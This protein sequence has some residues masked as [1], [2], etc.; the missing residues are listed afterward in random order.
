VIPVLVVGA[1]PAGLAT[2]FTLA[3]SGVESL[4]VER[5]PRPS[6]HPRA[7][8]ISTRSMEHL[9][10][11]GIDDEVLAGGVEVDWLMWH[12][13]TLA[14]AADGR[15]VEVGL[16]TRA[17][18]ALLSP[19][20]PACVPQDHLERVLLSRLRSL[21]P[22]TVLTSTELVDLESRP[23][24]V[25]AT[26]RDGAGRTR[27]VL[28]RY[29]VAADGARSTIRAALGIPMDGA[30]DVLGAVQAL[31]HAP[32][33]PSLGGQRYGAYWIEREGAQGLFLPA[34]A[35]A[36]LF[37]FLQDPGA[38]ASHV[39][40]PDEMTARIRLAAGM[41]ELPV[42]IES[43]A[44]FSSAAQV[45]ARFRHDDVF[46]VGDAAHRL[47][48][49][50]GTGMN[51]A[52]HDG[53]DLGWKLAWVLDG[54]ADPA[55]LDTYELERRPVAE[56]NVARSADPAGSTRSADE[57]LRADL[58]GRIG[59]HWVATPGGRV[60]TLDLV[61]P[62]LTLFTGPDGAAVAPTAPSGPPLVH[63]A[64]D[65]ITARALGIFGGGGVLVRPD[66]VPVAG[67]GAGLA[68]AA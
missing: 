46:L 12:C 37:G 38:P 48:P 13:E 4:L 21:E 26:L 62:G 2:A 67:A 28:A 65:A 59:H 39:P 45:A 53:V 31:F 41:P 17:Q 44:A 55:L 9:R 29:V 52:F 7:T 68:L 64:V 11:W 24:G 30:A 40:G 33:W 32:L 22:A 27:E 10:A 66:G 35:D 20:A 16:P 56:H 34:G 49:R 18:A 50:G 15:G 51:T 63:R 57:E 3:R 43:I 42:R 6:P 5:R 36:W 23:G 58:G 47:T 1:G 54:W 25:R 61:G 19:T 14:A 60:S 8:V